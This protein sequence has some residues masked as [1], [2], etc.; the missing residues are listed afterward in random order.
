MGT[1]RSGPACCAAEADSLCYAGGAGYGNS[2]FVCIGRTFTYSGSGTVTLAYDYANDTESGWDYSYVY[3]DTTGNGTDVKV[4]ICTG[5]GAARA[6]HVLA[7][8]N[9][10]AQRCRRVHGQ[11]L[12]VV[13]RRLQR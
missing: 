1:T 11:V 3:V 6:T 13:G 4:A 9:H 8:G 5:V 2:W 10:D 12:R 7:P